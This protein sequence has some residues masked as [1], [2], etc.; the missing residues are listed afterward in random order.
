MIRNAELIETNNKWILDLLNEN[1]S[2]R[3]GSLE[4]EFD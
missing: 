3:Q 1:T 4:I 2:M